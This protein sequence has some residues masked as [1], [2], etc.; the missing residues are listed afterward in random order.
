MNW[1]NVSFVIFTILVLVSILYWIPRQSSSLFGYRYG[2]LKKKNAA[3]FSNSLCQALTSSGISFE[4][5]FYQLPAYS[6]LAIHPTGGR[7]LIDCHT[8]SSTPDISYWSELER[9]RKNVKADEAWSIFQ[10]NS[11]N[12]SNWLDTANLQFIKTK[13]FSQINQ[14]LHHHIA[15]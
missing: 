15:H 8:W 1:L 13:S 10:S 11:G 9:L 2:P 12:W 4:R 14:W 7:I 5:E 3:D 6:L